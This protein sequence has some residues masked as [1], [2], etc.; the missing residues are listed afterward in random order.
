MNLW[1]IGM[2][3][4]GKT[5]LARALYARLKPTVPHLV[6]LDGDTVREAIG[7]DEYT[8][9]GRERQARRMSHLCKMLSDQGI[10]VITA[11]LSIFPDWQRW[12]RDN[13][14]GYLQVYLKTNLGELEKRDSKGLYS[15]ARSGNEPNVVGIDIEFPEPV[16]SDL[17]LDMAAERTDFDADLEAI[18]EILPA[19]ES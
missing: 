8:V 2:S 12:N 13:I 5:T 6:L 3:G 9:A 15:R 11:M 17:V 7:N 18:L 10:H 4:A 19:L 1:L 14:P 16:A